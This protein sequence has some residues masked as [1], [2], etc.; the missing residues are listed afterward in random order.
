M[1]KLPEDVLKTV[2]FKVS[3]RENDPN[4]TEVA[5][6]VKA[7][8]AVD[9]MMLKVPEH[10]DSKYI[11]VTLGSAHNLIPDAKLRTLG[12]PHPEN[13]AVQLLPKSREGKLMSRDG[14][15]PYLWTSDLTMNG[16][17]SGSPIFTDSGEVVGIAKA[18]LKIST[19]T[20][21]M[22]PIHFADSLIAY[23]R[24]RK[25]QEQIDTL[26]R[27]VGEKDPIDVELAKASLLGRVSE[28]ET[29]IDD[30]QTHVEWEGSMTSGD[31]FVTYS[32]LVAGGPAIESILVQVTPLQ[33]KEDGTPIANT[34]FEDILISV[35]EGSGA[36]AEGIFKVPGINELVQSSV[37]LKHKTIHK[38]SQMKV[39]VKMGLKNVVGTKSQ[40]FYVEL[41]DETISDVDY[42]RKNKKMRP[43][44]ESDV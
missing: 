41:D 10:F 1:P 8:A 19:S 14:P 29:N 18:E 7:D 40:L 34:T 35:P 2:K 24:I 17:Q 22:I 44:T 39:T 27:I 12:F 16:G 20:S 9:I 13:A 38:F 4:P 5:Q 30:L 33:S 43:R 11:P 23:I 25:M 28:I 21:F 26:I 31:L 6:F 3:F 37:L 42:V 32:K 15:S 36:G